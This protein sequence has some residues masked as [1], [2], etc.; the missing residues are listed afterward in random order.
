MALERWEDAVETITI[1]RT[2]KILGRLQEAFGGDETFTLKRIDHVSSMM[3]RFG[4]ED[5]VRK[6]LDSSPESRVFLRGVTED[7][8]SAL[9]LAACERFPS[10]VELL[11]ERG[12]SVDFQNRNGRTP[13]MQAALWGRYENV[14]RLQSDS[15]RRCV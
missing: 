6:Y 11:L 15:F 12:A 4:A 3:I 14:K 5:Y 8:N 13:L 2:D 1:D 9:W 10:V 7:G